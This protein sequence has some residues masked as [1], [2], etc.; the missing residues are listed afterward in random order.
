MQ[1]ACDSAA[2]SAGLVR[3]RGL[4]KVAQQCSGLSGRAL[5]K[6]PFLAHTQLSGSQGGR[7]G[8]SQA[9]CVEDFI[10][11]LSRAALCEAADRSCMQEAT[12]RRQP[13]AEQVSE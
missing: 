2:T 6:L 9:C 1:S 12:D 4:A 13:T 3:C 11:L 10:M 8:G 7:P 5:R